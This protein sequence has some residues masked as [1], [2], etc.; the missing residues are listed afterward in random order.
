MIEVGVTAGFSAAHR[1]RGDFGPARQ[2]HRHDYRVELRVAGDRL[3]EDGTLCDI[4]LLN[5]A[6]DRW[7]SRLE[8]RDLD[9]LVEFDGRNTTA[10]VV[11]AWLAD[12]L[13]VELREEGLSRVTA[14]VYESPDAWA[15]VERP[16]NGR[17]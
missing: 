10:E 2:R 1:L 16:L 3:R 15:S 8:G 12:G 13:A 4:G 7:T 6:L 17:R 11:A 14:R 5:Q 9:E